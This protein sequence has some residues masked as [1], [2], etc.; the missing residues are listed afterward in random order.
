MSSVKFPQTHCNTK[1]WRT[2]LNTFCYQ[3]IYI[4]SH[5]QADIKC[6]SCLKAFDSKVTDHA[7]N[8]CRVASKCI[9]CIWKI[10][11]WWKEL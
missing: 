11:R 6:G 3:N 1:L 8:I 9:K 5:N 2:F 4:K 10:N 7:G